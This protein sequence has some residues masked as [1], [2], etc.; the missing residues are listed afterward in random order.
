MEWHVKPPV[1]ASPVGQHGLLLRANQEPDGRRPK[2]GLSGTPLPA[3]Q[4]LLYLDLSGHVAVLCMTWNVC[5][6]WSVL[7]FVHALRFFF[8]PIVVVSGRYGQESSRSM[9]W[10][11]RYWQ[12]QSVRLDGRWRSSRN[13]LCGIFQKQS[14]CRHQDGRE[15]AMPSQFGCTQS[16]APTPTPKR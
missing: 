4:L 13:L 7:C 2:N 8:P 12:S 6:W 15:E 1:Q 11:T 9:T 10:K 16:V 3:Q 14:V 5:V